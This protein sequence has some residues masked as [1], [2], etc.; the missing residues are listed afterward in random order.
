[1]VNG[2]I[3]H[4]HSRAIFMQQTRDYQQIPFSGALGL[5]PGNPFAPFVIAALVIAIGAILVL[6]G[7]VLFGGTAETRYNAGMVLIFL[8]GLA[9]I[10]VGVLVIFSRGYSRI[11]RVLAGDYLV[12]WRY[13][14]TFPE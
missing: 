4:V 2:V 10:P 6:I 9:P 7:I 13:A 1:M 5:T 8:G 3:K 12:H 11:Q 14:T